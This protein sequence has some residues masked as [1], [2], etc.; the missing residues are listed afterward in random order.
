MWADVCNTMSISNV[1]D[2]RVA[3]SA[4][5]RS[6]NLA[7]S[8]RGRQALKAIDLEDQVLCS[9]IFLTEDNTCCFSTLAWSWF[10]PDSKHYWMPRTLYEDS[11]C[12]VFKLLNLARG[13]TFDIWVPWGIENKRRDVGQGDA[14]PPPDRL[15][16]R[17]ALNRMVDLY[18]RKCDLRW[19]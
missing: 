18:L 9:C 7:L 3:K 6:I 1:L 10:H 12:N 17:R 13:W 14:A 19:H 4:R 5:G 16:L 8:Y 11:F 15:L 2:I